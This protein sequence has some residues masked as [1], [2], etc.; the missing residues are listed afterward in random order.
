MKMIDNDLLYKNCIYSSIAHA[1]YVL[2]EPLFSYEQS[3]DENNF[4][5]HYGTTRGT[6]SFDLQKKIAV[7]VFRDE[8]SS[9]LKFYPGHIRAIDFLKNAPEYV[10]E[11]A[12]NE[13]MMYLYD[14]IGDYTGPVITATFWIKDNMIEFGENEISFLKHGGSILEIL[15]A[16]EI[17]LKDYWKKQ[18]DLSESENNLVNIIFKAFLQNNTEVILDSDLKKIKKEKGYM[19]MVNSL[20]EIGMNIK[21]RGLL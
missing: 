12:S 7:G 21:F 17:D 5:I 1:V 10:K 8:N 3:W 2:K 11:Y 19:E 4:S 20:K 15:I 9:Y 13:A 14:N 16:E 6:I 18:Y